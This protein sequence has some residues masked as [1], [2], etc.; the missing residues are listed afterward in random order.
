MADM[1]WLGSA[2]SGTIGGIASLIQTGVNSQ[3]VNNTNML[4][5]LQHNNDLD[6]NKAMTEKA[7]ER[8]DNY[9]QRSVADLEAA[10]LSPLAIS[11]SP[12]VSAPLSAP[13]A[14]TYQAP[15]MDL[16][17]LIQSALASAEMAET[18]R[19]NVKGEENK[20]DEIKNQAAEIKIKADSLKLENKKVE[21]QI[22]YQTK[23]NE[24]AANSLEESIRHAKAGEKISMS[25]E[26]GRRL[27]YESKRMYEEIKRRSGGKDIPYKFVKNPEEYTELFQI[28]QTALN[29]LTEK[30][31]KTRAG[32]SSSVSTNMQGGA[33]VAGTGLN[34]GAG[35]SKSISDYSDIS[36]QQEAMME[37]FYQEYPVLIPDF[38][39]YYE[40]LSKELKS[41]YK[42]D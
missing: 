33:T 13:T 2:I 10:G 39:G 37:K 17:G 9:Y 32:S 1:S 15:Q 21:E 7:W 30:L 40:N 18:K 26:A 11:G 31:G 29:E 25:E 14:P 6:Y 34:A 27:E 28:R 35:N 8:D 41:R 3:N 42:Y 24:I 22:R 23:L 38:D 12:S 5:M 4:N 16:N 36:K 19:H 20:A